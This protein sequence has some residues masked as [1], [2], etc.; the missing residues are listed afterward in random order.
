[1]DGFVV[2][3]RAKLQGLARHL[4]ASAGQA[5]FARPDCDAPWW[6]AVV[7]ADGSVRPCFF[8]EPVGDARDGLGAVLGSDEHRAALERIAAANDTCAR[9]VCPKLRQPQSRWQRLFG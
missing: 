6:S 7:E 2:E 5:E 4:R 9:C 8:H 1:M 3:S